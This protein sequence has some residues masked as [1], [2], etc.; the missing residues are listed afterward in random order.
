MNRLEILHLST[1]HKA[2]DNRITFGQALSLSKSFCVKVAGLKPR[3]I[4]DLPIELIEIKPGNIINRIIYALKIGIKIRPKA[5]QLHDPEMLLPGLLF[6]LF[7]I[8]I[9]FDFHEDFILK[10]QN[11][12]NKITLKSFIFK[13]IEKIAVPFYDLIVVADSHLFKKYN[14][15]KTILIGN[16]PPLKFTE[17]SKNKTDNIFNVVYL[18]TIHKERGLVKAV[19]AVNIVNI[20]NIK[21]HIIGNSRYPELTELFKKNDKVI[22]HGRINWED[23][24]QTLADMDVGLILLQPIPAF[25]YSPG[26]NIVKLFEYAGLGIPFIIS[27]FP[28]LRRFIE[29]NGGGILVDPTDV[30]EIAK[31]IEKLYKDKKLYS[32]LS[33][34]GIKM[35][36]NKYNWDN[37]EKKLIEA[38]KKILEK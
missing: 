1:S 34:E 2:E 23:L 4:K 9:I 25:T 6:K 35:V 29:K 22:Y 11:K 5:I 21:L 10:W 19:E 15:S 16:Y 13:L 32:K 24:N 8:K 31:N 27:D 17:I 7:G 28:G 3:K 26:E 30:N 14:S 38:Y 20:P 33:N 36:R 37:Q 18:G 12:H